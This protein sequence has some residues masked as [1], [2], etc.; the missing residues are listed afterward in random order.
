[1]GTKLV[2]NGLIPASIAAEGLWE[3]FHEQIELGFVD[4]AY[5]VM[6]ATG[7]MGGSSSSLRALSYKMEEVLNEAEGAR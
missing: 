3:V 1:M 4:A 6:F 2:G 5:G 7:A